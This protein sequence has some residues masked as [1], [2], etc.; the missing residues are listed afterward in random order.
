MIFIHEFEPKIHHLC[1]N[2]L[3]NPNISIEMIYK[4]IIDLILM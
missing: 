3:I 4:I 1:N 2:I